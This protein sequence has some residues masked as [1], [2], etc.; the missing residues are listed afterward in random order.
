LKP[1]RSAACADDEKDEESL[2]TNAAAKLIPAGPGGPGLP[3]VEDIRGIKPPVE[4]PN[5]WAWFWWTLAIAALAAIAFSIWWFKRKRN[6]GLPPIIVVPPHIRARQ[7]LDEALQFIS[8]PNQFCTRVAD[9]IRVYLEERFQLRAPERTTEEFL[10]ELQSSR[11][12]TA[13]QKQALGGFLQSCDLAKFARFE[14]TETVLRQLHEAAMRLVD[15]TQFR[16]VTP[17][18]TPPARLLTNAEP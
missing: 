3:A 13:D 8:E 12:L 15:E 2:K 14:P 18:T 9:T 6:L 1:G 10:L 17:A 7:R 11:H 16:A 4:I 5:E